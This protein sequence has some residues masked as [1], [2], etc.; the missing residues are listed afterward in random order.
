MK[1]GIDT[2]DDAEVGGKVVL[3]RVDINAPID[4]DTGGLRDV[5]RLRGCAPTVAALAD[6]GARVVLL[7]HQ[8]GELEF[9]NYAFTEPHASDGTGAVLSVDG[10][11]AV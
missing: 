3:Y 7:A 11:L 1:Y 2:L 9:R 6:C 10:G 4:P 8:G 5:T